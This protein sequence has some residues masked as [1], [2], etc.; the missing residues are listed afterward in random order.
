MDT[1][2]N[3]MCDPS[4]TVMRSTRWAAWLLLHSHKLLVSS[5]DAPSS[6]TKS[7]IVLLS[8]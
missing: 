5:S 2:G 4:F 3:R 6:R 8:A 7:V 1:A